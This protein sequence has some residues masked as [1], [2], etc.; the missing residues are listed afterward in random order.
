MQIHLAY[1]FLPRHF[2]NRLHVALMAMHAAIAQQAH[3]MEPIFTSLGLLQ[4]FAQH[5]V[6]VEAAFVDIFVDQGQI[7]KNN[8]ARAENHMADFG[9][10]HLSCRQTDID[11]GHRKPRVRI[12]AQHRVQVRLGSIGHCVA[13]F[14]RVDAETV[15]DD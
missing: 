9:I 8:P 3:E 11:S 12:V 6:M 5:F 15:Q 4:S 14:A 10:A 7:L 2:E 1:F 13:F